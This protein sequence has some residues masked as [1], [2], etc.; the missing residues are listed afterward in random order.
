M[1][2][3][4]ALARESI[5]KIDVAARQRLWSDGADVVDR[6]HHDRSGLVVGCRSRRAMIAMTATV[7]PGAQKKGPRHAALFRKGA[8]CLAAVQGSGR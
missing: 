3:L 5:S 8:R 6:C 2:S 1:L 4:I 7:A